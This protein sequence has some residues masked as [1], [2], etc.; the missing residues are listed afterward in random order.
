[1]SQSQYP[2]AGCGANVEFAPGTNVL[3]CPYCGHETELRPTGARVR[4]HDYRSFASLPRKPIA[5]LAKHV[6]TCRGCG[7]QTESDAISER[8]RFC[9]APVVAELNPRDLVVPEAVLPFA[10][11]QQQLR[12]TLG[13]W[14][15]SRWFAPTGLKKV[16]GAES[17][18]SMY[19]PFWTYDSRTVTDYDGR[20]GEHYW[21]TESYTMNGE[22]KTRRVRKTRWHA[23]SGTVTR[24]FDDL[25]VIGTTK[26]AHEHL[27]AI[28]PWTPTD[29]KAYRP[30]Y[31]AGHE[32][33]R[34]DV[35]PEA[36][37]DVAKQKM[38]PVIELDCREDIGG[39]EQ[40]VDHLDTEY[41]DVTF[42]LLLLPVWIACYLYAGK[43]YNIQVN[44][45]TGE[46][47]GERPYS[48]VKIALVVLGAL[49]VIAAIVGLYLHGKN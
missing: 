8:C 36:G 26:V 39:D 37:L 32:T 45:A 4:E 16:T 27:E 43:T 24:D 29:A 3:Q 31:L 20:R 6:F 49:A 42:K 5:L 13:G 35:E 34:Y 30:E 44:G 1:M 18:K 23:A 22:R 33:L 10:L 2:C 28:G 7:A 38:A 25:L 41:H 48:A 14:V 12:E 40:R 47:A 19:L 9:D 46:I 21:V 11:D 17:A 15:K